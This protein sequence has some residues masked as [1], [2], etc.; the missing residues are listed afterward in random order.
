MLRVGLAVGQPRPA[1]TFESQLADERTTDEATAAF[2]ISQRS[3]LCGSLCATTEQLAVDD[4]C[5]LS[6]M[7]RR[8]TMVCKATW[9]SQRMLPIQSAT[10]LL[11]D[12]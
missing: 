10:S 2:F 11:V 6:C 5:V 9:A 1:L 12:L 7:R 3:R 4:R 8:P